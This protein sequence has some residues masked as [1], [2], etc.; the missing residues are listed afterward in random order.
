[1]P[2]QNNDFVKRSIKFS[3]SLM[4]GLDFHK[5]EYKTLVLEEEPKMIPSQYCAYISLKSRIYE[6]G[7]TMIS[8][9]GLI[10]NY[11]KA[12]EIPLTGDP[13]LQVT[14]WNKADEIIEYDFCFPIK[15]LDSMPPSQAIKFKNTQEFKALK[16]IFNGNYRLSDRAWYELADYAGREG[17]KV[18][19]HPY[20]VYR[21]D[22]HSG[23]NE[24]EWVAEV[25]LPIQE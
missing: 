15:K 1:V 8:N 6:K 2:F 4:V 25:Y 21:N 10:M 9:I 18:L 5:K 13:F 22:P 7:N 19:M 12:N 11:I 16:A 24:L 14:S 23:G 20:E 17:I 3:K